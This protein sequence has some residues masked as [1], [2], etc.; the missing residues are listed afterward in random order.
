MKINLPLSKLN[1]N[2][3]CAEIGVWRGNFSKQILC[4][5]P[6]ELHLID[7][8]VHQDHI[9]RCYSVE[10]SAMDSVYNSVTDKFKKDKRVVI[11]RS[12]STE[13]SFPKEYFDWIYIDADHSYEAV[14]KDLNYY[15]PLM[16]SGGYMCGDDYG[17]W[18][19]RPESGRGSDANGGPKPAVDEFVKSKNLKLEVSD[20]H[21][22]DQFVIRCGE[23]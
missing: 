22:K 18:A 20:N 8:W 4:M 1:E 5:K 2:D 19:G 3:V 10:Q 16:K 23:D 12:F 9:R 11:H 14:L 15:Y 13:V 21:E 7:P 17:L 6:S